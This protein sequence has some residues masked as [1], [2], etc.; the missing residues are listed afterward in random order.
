M[1]DHSQI[2]T[3]LIKIAKALA[4]AGLFEMAVQTALK[5]EDESDRMITQ[6]G[7]VN[8]MALNGMYDDAKKLAD[9]L[10]PDS[11]GAQAYALLGRHL[12]NAG[13]QTSVVQSFEKALQYNLDTTGFCVITDAL[14]K[15]T[16][17]P[18]RESI[19]MKLLSL[20]RERKDRHD[21]NDV[22][23]LVSIARCAS[24][25][26]AESLSCQL[27][28]DAM[29]S[30]AVTGVHFDHQRKALAGIL[31]AFND[32]KL[33]GPSLLDRLREL[34]LPRA[35][36]SALCELDEEF[37]LSD[38]PWERDGVL[39]PMSVQSGNHPLQ[40]SRWRGFMTI[41]PQHT[42]VSYAVIGM[43]I[44]ELVNSGDMDGVRRISEKC[45][46]LGLETFLT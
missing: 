24:I 20:F 38:G 44:A 42:E 3:G 23:A 9:S 46:Q 26:G 11:E 37:C 35:T 40:L 22:L 14:S 32:S 27:F 28:L 8:L 21:K 5:I 29:E 31:A 17:L 1:S 13:N 25:I 36:L 19:L 15:T 45:P 33:A 4:K 2:T 12:S 34:N 7:I 43:F 10:G 41:C 39:S 30:L 18:G 6:V 16:E